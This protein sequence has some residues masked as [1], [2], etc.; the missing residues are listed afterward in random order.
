MRG[1]WWSPDGDALLVARVDDAP[2]QRWHIAD[3]ANP[4]RPPAVVAYPA[5]GTPNARVTLEI[6]ALDGTPDPGRLGRRARRV[7][8]RTR[9]GTP[10]SLLIVVQPRDQRALRVLRVDPAT[11]ATDAR[12]TSRPTRPG[13]TSSPAC[14]PTPRPAR[15]SRSADVDGARR[16]VVDGEPVTPPSLQVRDVLDVDGDTV[17]FRGERATRRSIGL[18]TWGPDGLTA[19]DPGARA[20]TAGGSPAARWSSPGRT[21]D[22]DGTTTTVHRATAPSRTIASFAEPP[23]PAPRGHAAQRRARAS[24]APRCCCR[25]GTSRAPRCRC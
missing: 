15:W 21:C 5:A 17:L 25:P 10:T 23:G 13:W 24:C 7:P 18:W 3:P 2:V 12:C 14:P 1:Y 8:R 6:I 19:A 16:L 9:S 11:G 22:A 20:C 4:D